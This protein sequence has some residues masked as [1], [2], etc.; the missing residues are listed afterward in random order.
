MN[1]L[2]FAMKKPSLQLA[3]LAVFTLLC[4][5][6]VSGAEALDRMEVRSAVSS[7]V[8]LIRYAHRLQ[9]KV[10]ANWQTPDSLEDFDEDLKPAVVSFWVLHDGRILGAKVQKSTGEEELDDLALKAVQRSKPFPK[11]PDDLKERNSM[12][13]SIQF[14]Y[15]ANH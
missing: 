12:K 9:D 6:N 13:V 2:V 11:F 3:L 15:I 1:A 4:A 7:E 5:G 10:Y 14:R 8:S